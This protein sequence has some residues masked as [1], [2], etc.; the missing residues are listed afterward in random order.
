MPQ[1]DVTKMATPALKSEFRALAD[2]LQPLTAR[3]KVIAD[4]MKAREFT[5]RQF[6]HM[7]RKE[8]V[9]LYNDLK[10]DLER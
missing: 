3:R 9:A 1:N 4:E 7:T 6:K 5:G 8:K 10:T 2:A